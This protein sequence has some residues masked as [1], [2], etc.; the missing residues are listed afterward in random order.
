[1]LYEKNVYL[2][3]ISYAKI[4]YYKKG[5]SKKSIEFLKV[6]CKFSYK[7]VYS[8]TSIIVHPQNQKLV[9]NYGGCAIIELLL[10]L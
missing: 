3:K 2:I 5:H 6:I 9:C 10:S 1:M 4:V 8:Q 7:S